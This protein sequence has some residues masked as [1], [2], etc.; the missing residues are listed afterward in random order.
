MALKGIIAALFIALTASITNARILGLDDSVPLSAEDEVRY[1]GTGRIECSTPRGE[2][3]ATAW[4]SGSKFTIVTVAHAFTNSI[5]NTDYPIDKCKFILYDNNGNTVDVIPI[6]SLQSRWI[7]SKRPARRRDSSH[8]IAIVRLQRAPNV[9]ISWPPIVSMDIQSQ[10]VATI[11]GF[12]GFNR[13]KV[14]SS[15]RVYPMSI[16]AKALIRKTS[17]AENL[18]V[19]SYDS[20]GAQ[21][22][23]RIIDYQTHQVIGMH[24]GFAGYLDN[25]VRE[26]DQHRHFNYFLSFDQEFARDLKKI[27]KQASCETGTCD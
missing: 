1:S 15:G 12:G 13:V 20:T 21:S 7:D 11:L 8:D 17:T 19:G 3:L 18:H 23:S 5:T 22:G 16:E 10:K 6:Y 26:F 14:K 2:A 27:A 24:I 4:F 9:R 25:I